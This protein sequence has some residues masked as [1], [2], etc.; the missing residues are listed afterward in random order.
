MEEQ[1]GCKWKHNEV[2]SQ[3]MG[4]WLNVLINGITHLSIYK[5]AVISFQT[6][7]N[8]PKPWQFWK[9]KEYIIEITYKGGIQDKA[10]YQSHELWQDIINELTF[11][12]PK[13][14]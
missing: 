11:N 12:L 2:V 14:I 1:P 7:V 8:N 4:A 13:G 5:P 10:D 6:W 3:T 9:E